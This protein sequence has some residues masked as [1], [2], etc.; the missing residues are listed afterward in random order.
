MQNKYTCNR[1]ALWRLTVIALTLWSST[2]SPK[3]EAEAT[4]KYRSTTNIPTF[5]ED[6]GARPRYN[7]HFEESI[8]SE[9]Q[10]SKLYPKPLVQTT[11]DDID[12]ASRF[13]KPSEQFM[14]RMGTKQRYICRVPPLLAKKLNTSTPSTAEESSGSK[15]IL[16]D[17]KPKSEAELEAERVQNATKLLEPMAGSCIYNN[18]GWWTYEFCYGKSIRQIHEPID[19]TDEAVTHELGKYSKRIPIT[20]NDVISGPVSF[21]SDDTAAVDVSSNGQSESATAV[22]GNRDGATAPDL[23]GERR[24]LTQ[25]WTG[26]SICDLTGKQRSIEVQFFCNQQEGEKIS[27]A[28]E[29]GTCRYVMIVHT[30]RLCQ[31]PVFAGVQRGEADKINCQLVVKDEVYL[32]AKERAH[33]RINKKNIKET[34]AAAAAATLKLINHQIPN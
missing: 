14:M 13:L 34:A 24:F 22:S 7:M 29:P 12:D 20:T 17:K 31:D 10:L 3:V 2:S 23:S 9:S 15:D 27:Y 19:D 26:G 4:V 18:Q 30:P 11:P 25:H 32:R 33:A 16:I 21:E 6:I 5:I 1:P 28:D 8:I